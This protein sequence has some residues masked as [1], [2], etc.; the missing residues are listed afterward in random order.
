MYLQGGISLDIPVFQTEG[1]FIHDTHTCVGLEFNL[2]V[3]TAED[4]ER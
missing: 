4:I 2:V 3:I 1:L